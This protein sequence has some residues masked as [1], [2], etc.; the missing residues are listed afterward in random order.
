MKNSKLKYI[1]IEDDTNVW[2]NIRERMNVFENWQPVEFSSELTDAL[3]KIESEKPELI[4]TD[5]S[6]RGGN[7]YHILDKIKGIRNY[8]PYII[9]FTGYQ[10]ENPEIP[11]KI[12]ND[13]SI[14][15]KKYIIKP[16][17]ENLTNH[18]ADYVKEAEQNAEKPEEEIWIEDYSKRKLKIKPA[19][20][21]AFLQIPDRPRLKEIII[22]D[23]PSVIVKYKWEDCMFL[24][25]KYGLDFFVTYHRKS[26]IN[27]KFIKKLDNR[28]VILSNN[29]V[30]DVS[31][32][33]WRE[34]EEING[35]ESF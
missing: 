20:C 6:I 13:Y 2:D 14:M 35:L 9:F 5:W 17:Y 7:A 21:M 28:K 1:V 32:E 15:V 29:T 33:Q 11:Q 18:L 25:E 10:S 34:M 22:R 30:V 23:M 12:F 4:F 27:K 8:S 31:R 3:Q 26:I 24:I 19:D 16:I